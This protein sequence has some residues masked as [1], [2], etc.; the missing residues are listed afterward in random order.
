[1]TCEPL[2]GLFKQAWQLLEA[3]AARD[4]DSRT[5]P[6]PQD[7]G[8]VSWNWLCL[9]VRL[10]PALPH[11]HMSHRAPRGLMPTAAWILVL[12]AL[13]A[14]RCAQL[15]SQGFWLLPLAP[16]RERLQEVITQFPSAIAS[17]GELPGQISKPWTA[18]NLSIKKRI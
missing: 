13:E 2:L 16:L 10:Q 18:L 6:S 7:C 9:T 5:G 4:L 1:M 12:W 15:H 11:L 14:L 3:V 8:A 17:W